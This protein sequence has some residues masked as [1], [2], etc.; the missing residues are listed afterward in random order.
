MPKK[1]WEEVKLPKNYMEALK[2]VS[3][4]LQHWPA[5]VV[6]R[7][8]QRLTKLRQVIIRE[9]KQVLGKTKN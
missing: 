6:N 9:R 7:C 4:N 5:H 8:K 1:L 3:E 2:V